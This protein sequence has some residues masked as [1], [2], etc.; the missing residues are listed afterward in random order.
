MVPLKND[1]NSIPA[2][3]EFIIKENY[4]NVTNLIIHG[5][6]LM[7]GLR[8]TTLDKLK[9]KIRVPLI[10]T[11]ETCLMTIILTGQ[12]SLCYHTFLRLTS[13]CDFRK[14]DK[15]LNIFDC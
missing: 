14:R 1:I 3:W 12:Q 7:K 11:S 4:E 15:F 6:C 10:F 13:T 8:V 5:H 9:F 2:K